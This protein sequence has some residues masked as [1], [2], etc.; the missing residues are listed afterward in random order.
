MKTIEEIREITKNTI[1][2]R[3]KKSIEACTNFIENIIEPNI[4]AEAKRGYVRTFVRTNSLIS[5]EIDYIISVYEKKGYKVKYS[6]FVD[7]IEICWE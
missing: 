4:L 5:S 3:E 1:E 7:D 2:E 6:A